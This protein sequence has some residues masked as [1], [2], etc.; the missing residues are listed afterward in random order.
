MTMT[1][2]KIKNIISELNNI[3]TNIDHHQTEISKI[4]DHLKPLYDAFGTYMDTLDDS[5][6]DLCGGS[7]TIKNTISN[8][9]MNESKEKKINPLLY[10]LDS[11]GNF[12]E[13]L[14]KKAT[15]EIVD[16]ILSQRE[17]ILEAFIAETGLL[18]SE[19]ELVNQENK[20]WI[21]KRHICSDE[22]I[23]QDRDIPCGRAKKDQYYAHEVVHIVENADDATTCCGRIMDHEW[24]HDV[25]SSEKVTCNKCLEAIKEKDKII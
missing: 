2:K 16:N 17:K 12:D 8:L 4:R 14:L 6:N 22:I 23:E 15:N 9:P 25:Y 18:P 10:V 13:A 1:S 21:Q 3:V 19:C 24:E 5:I 7:E 11:D 20:W